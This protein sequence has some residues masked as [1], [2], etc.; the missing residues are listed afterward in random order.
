M[1]PDAIFSS[2]LPS[3]VLWVWYFG[4]GN[5]FFILLA[6]NQWNLAPTKISNV[7]FANNEE[8][9]IAKLTQIVFSIVSI[10]QKCS[11]WMT[12]RGVKRNTKTKKLRCHL[13]I[14]MD[15]YQ[16]A[17]AVLIALLSRHLMRCLW[18]CCNCLHSER[19]AEEWVPSLS[20]SISRWRAGH[21]VD[22]MCISSVRYLVQSE[23][24]VLLRKIFV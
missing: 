4:W 16:K 7:C 3:T 9:Y 14:E 23:N 12:S 2:F 11:N 15:T 13:S 22:E 17:L 5:L 19:S 10:V 6:G 18:S 21:A 24:H 20:S 8:N 1:N